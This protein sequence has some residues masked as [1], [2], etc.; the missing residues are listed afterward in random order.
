MN[1]NLRAANYEV[2][3]VHLR[4]SSLNLQFYCYEG[5][6]L[7][8]RNFKTVG[9]M[10][11]I[12]K[13][14]RAKAMTLGCYCS[15]NLKMSLNISLTVIKT[16]K[17]KHFIAFSLR[18]SVEG[19]AVY[20]FTLLKPCLGSEKTKISLFIVNNV[21]FTHFLSTSIAFAF[22]IFLANY[23]CLGLGKVVRHCKS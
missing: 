21:A 11:V 1:L 5:L 19:C 17:N 23:K 10:A 15:A 20:K 2:L 18:L 12:I 9:F 13:T 3:M 6:R 4:N 22:A 14:V 16:I 7:S 8:Q